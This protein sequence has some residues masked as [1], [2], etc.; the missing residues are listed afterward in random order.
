MSASKLRFTVICNWEVA[1]VYHFGLALLKMLK[2]F[3][4]S[5]CIIYSFESM[6]E[7]TVM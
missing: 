6:F 4:L 5:S 1:V 7:S 3:L 2:C